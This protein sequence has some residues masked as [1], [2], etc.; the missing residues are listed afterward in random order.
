[1]KVTLRR[2]RVLSAAMAIATL[3]L[4]LKRA[5]AEEAF[6]SRRIDLII[7]QGAGA[8]TDVFARIIAEGLSRK[9]GQP[10]IAINRPGGNGIIAAHA[11]LSAPPSGYTL[12]ILANGLVIDQALGRNPGFDVRKNLVPVARASLATPGLFV[13]NKLPVSSVKELIRYAKQN[14]GRI[15]Y[16]S[17]A[18]GSVAHL[19]TERL[20]RATGIDMV[21]LP[22]PGGTAQ[23]IPALLSGDVGVFINE[24]GSMRGVVESGDVRL[25]ATL[26]DKRSPIFPEV[27][28][29]SELGIPEIAGIFFPFYFGF[30]VA[31]GTDQEK[32]EILASDINAVL[33]DEPTRSRLIELGY[34]TTLL[35]GTRPAEFSKLIDRELARVMD[36]IKET[37]IPRQ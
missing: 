23:I 8:A 32:V 22:F 28:A 21:H 20:K 27:P 24:M 10:V 34:D 33:Q 9:M 5:E 19:T 1:M 4:P 37:N 7:P 35:G 16:A 11:M 12:L 2:L 30:F 3:C 25:L 31:P 29:V 36:I 18:V 15:N 26:G 6:P 13:S 14:P 17:P